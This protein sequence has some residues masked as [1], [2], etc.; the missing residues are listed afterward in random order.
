MV[1]MHGL[2]MAGEQRPVYPAWIHW[3]GGDKGL[4]SGSNE[5]PRT[6]RGVGLDGRAWLGRPLNGRLGEIEST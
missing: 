1:R 2:W 5:T 6:G 3:S 4:M